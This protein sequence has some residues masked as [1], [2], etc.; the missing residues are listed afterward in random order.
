MLSSFLFLQ[1]AHFASYS[2]LADHGS[3]NPASHSCNNAMLN[4]SLPH[5]S[6][7]LMSELCLR[8]SWFRSLELVNYAL[9]FLLPGAMDVEL[10]S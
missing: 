9:T 6:F 3:N 1:N 8:P 2:F 7:L 5:L 10:E 4:C